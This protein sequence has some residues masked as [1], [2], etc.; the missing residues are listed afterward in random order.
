MCGFVGYI[1]EKKR[2]INVLK[3]MLNSIDHRGPDDFSTYS[4]GNY[5][6]GM[7]RLAINDLEKGNQPIFNSS[8]SIS[9]FYNGEI[10]NSPELRELLQKKGYRL[11]SSSDGEVIGHLF[12]EYNTN[13]FEMLDGMFSIA[14]WDNLK[15]ELFLVRDPVGEKPLYF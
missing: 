4:S 15:K 8:K 5:N 11:R 2:D 14:L 9:I 13:C 6:A 3:K 10:Y 7:C 1:G 12:D